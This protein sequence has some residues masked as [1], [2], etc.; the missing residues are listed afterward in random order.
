MGADFYTRM[1]KE[2]GAV[3]MDEL[4]KDRRKVVKAYDHYVKLLDKYENLLSCEPF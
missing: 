2:I 1:L 4:E 3:E